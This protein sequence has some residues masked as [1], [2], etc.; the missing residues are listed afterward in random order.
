MAKLE[1]LNCDKSIKKNSF[2]KLATEIL[3]NP[4]KQF[5]P[6][7]NIFL[8]IIILVKT[9]GHLDNGRDVLGQPF[10]IFGHILN[11]CNIPQLDNPSP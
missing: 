8:T 9:T 3:I 2:I 6:E 1:K 10:A 4:N 7:K 5:S 11:F